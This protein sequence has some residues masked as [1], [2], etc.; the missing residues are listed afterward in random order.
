MVSGP[1]L[2][3]ITSFACSSLRGLW[4]ASSVSEMVSAPNA[5]RATVEIK[6]TNV[7]PQI[8]RSFMQRTPNPNIFR[9][10]KLNLGQGLFVQD[11]QAAPCL[12][13]LSFVVDT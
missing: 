12:L 2:T 10:S 8:R 11:E 7:H 5:D 4:V 1:G 3:G 9:L 13:G 6:A